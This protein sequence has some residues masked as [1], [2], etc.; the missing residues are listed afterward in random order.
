[1]LPLISPTRVRTVRPEGGEHE[2]RRDRDPPHDPAQDRAVRPHEHRGHGE[3]G[4]DRGHQHEE[5]DR[6][7]E[8][9][10]EQIRDAPRR[11]TARSKGRR[12]WRGAVR[13]RGGRARRHEHPD[14]RLR[15]RRPRP[16]LTTHPNSVGGP[17]V[18]RASTMG[19]V[20]ARQA[21]CHR[22]SGPLRSTFARAERQYEQERHGDDAPVG[23]GVIGR[24]LRAADRGAGLR[25]D[26]GLRGR[27]RRVAPRRGRG[28]GAARACRRRPRRGA[29]AA[30]LPPRPGRRRALE[31]GKAVLCDKPFG[32]DADDAARDGSRRARRGRRRAA[33]LR[34][35]PPPGARPRSASWCRRARSARSSTC[36]GARS[37]PVHASRCAGTGGC[38]TRRA[39]A[40]GSARGART[41]STSCAGPSAR[42]PTRPRDAHAPPSP[43][44]RTATA[45]GSSAPRRTGSPRGC[46]PRAAPRVTIDTTFAAPAQRADRASPCSAPTACSSRSPTSASRCAPTTAST[47]VFAFD[48]PA[49]DPH[50]VPM[51]AWAR[52]RARRGARRQG[53]RRRTDL[54]RRRRVRAGDGPPQSLK[55]DRMTRDVASRPQPVDPVAHVLRD[56]R[57]HPV[58]LWTLQH[59]AFVAH[60]RRRAAGAHVTQE[61]GPRSR[62]ERACTAM[63]FSDTPLS[64]AWLRGGHGPTIRLPCDIHRRSVTPPR[65]HCCSGARACTGASTGASGCACA[66]ASNDFGTTPRWR[67]TAGTAARWARRSRTS[68]SRENAIPAGCPIAPTGGED[69]P[70]SARPEQGAVDRGARPGPHSHSARRARA[71]IS[72]TTSLLAVA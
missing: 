51:R 28:G 38:S 30:V 23:I 4:A 22:R 45:T 43:N 54:R 42:S 5:Q 19:R 26:R 57:V 17:S 24:G 59:S 21:S 40:A 33:Q 37:T 63:A 10:L 60:R 9:R 6:G 52:G 1:M 16:L 41:P 3:R 12:A 71:R 56:D 35:P 29:L 53:P 72:S 31:A 49:E 48:A 50:L 2:N 25:R 67:R 39:A 7:D 20:D 47:E 69:V 70:V 58:G 18:R 15:R 65:A 66:G 32:C 36:S 64:A 14:V 46:A 27:R 61:L 8:G 55:I 13:R 44:D 68:P 62:R 34:V 11:A